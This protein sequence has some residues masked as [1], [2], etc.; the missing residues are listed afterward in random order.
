MPTEAAV[1]VTPFC[2][3][4]DCCLPLI[5]PG[6]PGTDCPGAPFVDPGTTAYVS[7]SGADYL[8]AVERSD[9]FLYQTELLWRALIDLSHTQELR[10]RVSSSFLAPF[11]GSIF[12]I[13]ATACPLHS[14]VFLG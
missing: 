7:G 5:F 1:Q 11:G 9:F 8:R 12:P 3:C 13:R 14:S 2:G 10:N 6:V 4:A